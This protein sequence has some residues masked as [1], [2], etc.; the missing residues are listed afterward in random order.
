MDDI[1][2]PR[3][4][5]ELAFQPDLGGGFADDD[6]VV[7]MESLNLSSSIDLTSVSGNDSVLKP[8]GDADLDL[9]QCPP[10]GTSF[11]DAASLN[12]SLSSPNIQAK[13]TRKRRALEL[14]MTT[15]LSDE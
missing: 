4:G 12:L 5:N 15:E 8:S 6:G 14:D 13:K 2:L 11:N 7:P 1:E 3:D 9:T 10:T